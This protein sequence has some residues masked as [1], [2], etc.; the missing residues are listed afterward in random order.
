[1]TS[2]VCGLTSFP[3][4]IGP[5]A[6]ADGSLIDVRG[7]L[8]RLKILDQ[9]VQKT[10][11]DLSSPGPGE[12]AKSRSSS[13]VE[14]HPRPMTDSFSS[15]EPWQEGADDFEPGSAS[16]VLRG[17]ASLPHII[18]GDK[19]DFVCS[20]SESDVAAGSGART[21][22]ADVDAEDSS[23]AVVLRPTPARLGAS[24][25]EDD[26]SPS[27]SSVVDSPLPTLP[28]GQK[29]YDYLLKFLLVGDSDVGKQEILASFEDG[30]TE[31]P[32]CSS[33]G[34]GNGERASF[35]RHDHYGITVTKAM[36]NLMILL[37]VGLGAVA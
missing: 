13:S 6:D 32:F 31:S 30:T 24:L 35:D 3:C 29:S 1:V 18:T 2:P 14:S 23:D 4:Y 15:N 10:S 16:Q 26:H 33:S 37:M 12:R 27:L 25:Y 7:R 19:S 8:D 36:K 11:M 22:D 21:A 5:D 28:H 9:A 34:A 17:A 20:K